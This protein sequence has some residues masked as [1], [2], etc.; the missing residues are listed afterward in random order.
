MNISAIKSISIESDGLSR[1]RICGSEVIV[2]RGQIECYFGY[3]WPVYDCDDCG[4]R[5]TLHDNSVYDWFY[6]E[7]RSSY[8]RYSS[9]VAKCRRLFDLGDQASLRSEYL[10]G[11]KYEFI[12]KHI[13]REPPNAKILEIG[14]SRGHLTSYFILGGRKITGGDI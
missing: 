10:Q 1:C 2:K 4:C 7:N 9:Q 12:I 11:S 6:S 14:S 8:S 3:A 5:F 13:D